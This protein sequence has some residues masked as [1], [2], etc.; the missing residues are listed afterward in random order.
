M[1]SLVRSE[2]K[3]FECKDMNNQSIIVA[4]LGSSGGSGNVGKND[5]IAILNDKM[6]PNDSNRCI[7]VLDNVKLTP[8][9]KNDILTYFPR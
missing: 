4:Y 5:I 6:K 1:E 2:N 8:A 9:A 3:D 7:L